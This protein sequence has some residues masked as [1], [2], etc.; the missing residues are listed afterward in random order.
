MPMKEK[1]IMVIKY[2]AFLCYF[3]FFVYNILN[4]D[5][6][7]RYCI[8]G[9]PQPEQQRGGKITSGLATLFYFTILDFQV[10]TRVENPRYESE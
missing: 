2:G 5:Q 7:K 3:L 9:N 4:V 1:N 10:K 6:T 8:L